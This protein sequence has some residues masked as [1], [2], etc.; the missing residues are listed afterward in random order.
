MA[1]MYSLE[2]TNNQRVSSSDSISER[3]R[4]MCGFASLIPFHQCWARSL[5]DQ[6]VA[7]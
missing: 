1:G 4:G 7:R 2:S 3:V 5:G 6:Q